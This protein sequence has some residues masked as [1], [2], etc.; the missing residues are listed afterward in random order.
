MARIE[1][2]ETSPTVGTLERLLAAAGFD[3]ETRLEPQVELD[4]QLFDD[5]RRILSMSPEDRLR[6]VGN[7]SRF[8]AEARRA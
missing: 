5:V 2:G 7:V 4:P 1:T 6:E 3:L 8:L